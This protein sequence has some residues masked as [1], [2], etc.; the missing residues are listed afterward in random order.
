[1]E[2]ISIAFTLFLLMDAPGNIPLFVAIL[3]GFSEKRQKKIILRELC[4]ALGVV[5]LFAIAGQELLTFLKIKQYTIQVS[6]GIILFLIA[7]KMIFPADTDHAPRQEVKEPFIVPLA[8]PLIA[9]PACLAAVI[10]YSHSISMVTL[11]SA[12]IL[13][14]CLTT[15]M[16]MGSSKLHKILGSKGLIACERLMGLI[17]TLMATQMFLEG[18]ECFLKPSCQTMMK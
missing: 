13:S 5:I 12:I 3:K 2:I 16:L 7:L 17:L 14:W 1:M 10:I 11:I 4:I 6:G 15:L 8:V 18:L 9:G